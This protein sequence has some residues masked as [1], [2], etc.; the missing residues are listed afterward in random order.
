MPDFARRVGWMP[1][2]SG[3]V[4]V[5]GLGITPLLLILAADGVVA[6]LIFRAVRDEWHRR[7]ARRPS[8]AV[9]LR[10]EPTPR[11]WLAMR[12]GLPHSIRRELAAPS[13][14]VPSGLA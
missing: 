12:L 6:V 2:I 5:F 7:Q 10:L 11:S 13:E 1:V 4:I 3:L 14:P 8:L 9:R